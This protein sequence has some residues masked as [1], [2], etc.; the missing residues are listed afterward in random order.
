M[1]EKEKEKTPAAF[2]RYAFAD[3]A[4]RMSQ[5]KSDAGYMSGAID[6]LGKNL[7]F[8]EDGGDLYNWFV[9]EKQ[10]KKLIDIY[11]EK[12]DSKLTEASVAD[13]FEWYK[14]ALNGATDEQKALVSAAFGKYAGENY[15]KLLGKIGTLQYKYKAPE[16]AITEEERKAVG[17]ELAKYQDFVLARSLLDSY[18]FEALRFQA[19]EASKP[20]AFG[21]L[22]EL[23]Q[24]MN[25]PKKEGKK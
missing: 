16:G 4:A 15:T 9:T 2:Q 13:V 22:E 11:S 21:G 24:K 19:V 17:E 23:V 5:S 12:F 1:A 20:S 8:G 7:N 6:L 25:P 3:V 10:T 14:P 18:N